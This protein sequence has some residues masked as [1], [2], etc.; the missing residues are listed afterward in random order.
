MHRQLMFILAVSVEETHEDANRSA[1]LD[2]PAR[3]KADLGVEARLDK[4]RRERNGEVLFRLER[5]EEQY[6]SKKLRTLTA[7]IARRVSQPGFDD[8]SDQNLQDFTMMNNLKDLDSEIIKTRELVA[9]S[10]ITWNQHFRRVEQLNAGLSCSLRFRGA[11][12]QKKRSAKAAEK[13]KALAVERKQ[14]IHAMALDFQKKFPFKKKA[15][16]RR[17]IY[18]T[19]KDTPQKLTARTILNHYPN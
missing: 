4:E 15:Y 10:D 18:N 19:L 6:R 1:S 8:W 5:I 17:L 2:L 13:K 11:Q 12:D 9:N 3:M 14:K 7:E 16:I